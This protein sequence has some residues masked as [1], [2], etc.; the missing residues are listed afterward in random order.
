MQRK[1]IALLLAVVML[2]S[3]CTMSGCRR[4]KAVDNTVSIKSDI[5][6]GDATVT[7]PAGA[8]VTLDL[9]GFTVSGTCNK[10]SSSALS[11]QNTAKL[12]ITDSVGGGKLTYAAGSSN[13]GWAIYAEGELVLESGTIELTGSW[14][15]GYCVD[16]R[17]NAWGTAHTAPASFVMNGGKIIRDGTP[18]FVFGDPRTMWDADLDVPQTTELLFKL[19]EAGLDLPLDEFDVQKCAAVIAAE[20]RRKME[21]RG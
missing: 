12:T 2:F 13:V 5:D 6:L 14:S 9:A 1:I 7:I 3:I 16:L 20:V 8:D 15:I 10:G 4:G 18:K 19:R 21:A 17:P 11:V